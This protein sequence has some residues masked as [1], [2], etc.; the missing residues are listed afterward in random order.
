MVR[1]AA[2]SGGKAAVERPWYEVD[3]SM[4]GMEDGGGGGGCAAVGAGAGGA[5]CVGGA[6]EVG[7]A[8]DVE[9]LAAAVDRAGAG[10]AAWET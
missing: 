3:Q 8:G 1:W 2:T 9:A 7:P 5:V 10:F 4:V 6:V